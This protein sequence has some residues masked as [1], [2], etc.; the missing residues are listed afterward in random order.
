M[1][2]LVLQ[3]A[4]VPNRLPTLSC[5]PSPQLLAVA[6]TLGLSGLGKYRSADIIYSIADVGIGTRSI[7]RTDYGHTEV[8]AHFGNGQS[9]VDYDAARYLTTFIILDPREYCISTKEFI[10]DE[11]GKLSG[12][13]T[14]LFIC[15]FSQISAHSFRQFVW[16]GLKTVVDVGRWRKFRDLR[17]SSPLN[18]YSSHWASWDPNLMS[19]RVLV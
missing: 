8:A 9:I 6:I 12:L 17:N 2:V 11:E 4:M 13:N 3:C 14:G 15:W 1:I 18:S 7:F 16:N 5:F 19:L 10:V